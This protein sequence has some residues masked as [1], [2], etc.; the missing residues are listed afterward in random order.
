[1]CGR[2]LYLYGFVRPDLLGPIDV[3]GVEEGVAVETIA[4]QGL[5]ALVSDVPLDAFREATRQEGPD[6]SWLVPR[7][8]RH[9]QAITAV[10]ALSP[11]LPV[12]FGALFTNR[13]AL[14][15]LV[16][17]HADV[18][19]KFLNEVIGKAEWSVRGYVELDSLADRL[20]VVDP[21]LAERHRALP[22][23]PGARYF[24]AKRLREDAL[25]LARRAGRDRAQRVLELA[26]TVLGETHTLPRRAAEHAGREMV[27]HVACLLAQADL[28]RALDALRS[29]ADGGRGDSLEIEVTGPWPPF[30]FCPSLDTTRDSS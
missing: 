4:L 17:I 29:A 2:G 11:V 22:T 14:D 23:T 27:F 25:K 10:M 5:A 6:P 21:G 28:E 26:R 16:A 15:E 7:A 8:L 18:I 24:Q 9:E 1:M 30:H 13:G 3:E 19:I 20:V 12:R